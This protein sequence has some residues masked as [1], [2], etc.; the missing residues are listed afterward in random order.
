MTKS[1]QYWYSGFLYKRG[2]HGLSFGY[3]FFSGK[4]NI[5][6]TSKRR[7]D[8]DST[9][10]PR[11]LGLHHDYTE[12]QSIKWSDIPNTK[13]WTYNIKLQP[14]QRSNTLLCL[15]E[16]AVLNT[17]S[18]AERLLAQESITL[19]GNSGFLYNRNYND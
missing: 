2:D 18:V 16:V 10:K 11:S 6:S 9:T 17:I 7:A 13:S 12:D 1:W 19:K 5:G 3:F 8:V 14:K 4:T 15:I